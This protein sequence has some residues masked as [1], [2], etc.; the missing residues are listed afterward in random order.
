MSRSFCWSDSE[1]ILKRVRRETVL[2]EEDMLKWSFWKCFCAVGN[3]VS[4]ELF[5]LDRIR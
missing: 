5:F 2:L 3:V 4:R 1:G